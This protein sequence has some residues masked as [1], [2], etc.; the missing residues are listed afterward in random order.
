MEEMGAAGM[1]AIQRTLKAAQKEA[2]VRGRFAIKQEKGGTFIL[3]KGGKPIATIPFA[4]SN[5]K[6]YL[7]SILTKYEK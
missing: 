7:I 4:K 5:D 1:G 2:G 6:N 3:L